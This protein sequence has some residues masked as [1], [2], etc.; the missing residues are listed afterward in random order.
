MGLN[1]A[2]LLKKG[3]VRR[4]GTSVKFKSLYDEKWAKLK[5][6]EQKGL[7]YIHA[8][9]SLCL[10]ISRNQSYPKPKL[11]T[12]RTHN[13]R[14]NVPKLAQIVNKGDV[15]RI[16]TSVK[17]KSLCDEKWAKQKYQPKM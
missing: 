13:E 5:I 3:D 12:K 10:K 2:K 11:F 6:L 4:I 9:K 8:L 14:Q 7:E 1:W 15:R 16:G 17:F